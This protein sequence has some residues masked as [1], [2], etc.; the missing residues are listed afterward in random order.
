M[1]R[2]YAQGI[3]ILLLFLNIPEVRGDMRNKIAFYRPAVM[4][5]LTLLKDKAEPAM[6]S[7]MG[8]LMANTKTILQSNGKAIKVVNPSYSAQVNTE[9]SWTLDHPPSIT[10]SQFDAVLRDYNSPASGIGQHVYD[11]AKAK[12]IDN[13]YALFI[14]IH[15]STAGTNQNW[16]GMKGGGNS[17]HNPGN[18]ICAGY[19]SCYGGFR[20]YATWEDGFDALI[21]LLAYYRDNLGDKDINA[22]IYRWAPPSE[23]DTDGYIAQL[24]ENVGKWRGVNKG[25][26]VATSEESGIPTVSNPIGEALAKALAPAA[27]NPNGGFDKTTSNLTLSGCLKDT[28]P[29]ALDPSP[30]LKDVTIPP[31]TDWSFNENWVIVNP[32][33]H[34]CGNINYGGVCDMATRYNIAAKELGLQ[35]MYPRHPGGLN[36][37]DPD[38]AVVIMSDGSR[39]GQDLVIVNNTNKTVR[40]QAQMQE[41]NV[42]SVSAWY[43]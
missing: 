9:N 5:Q 1:G 7:I 24:K 15:E 16:A 37:V 41:G 4:Q 22:A 18:I 29:N 19:S 10:A 30:N 40:M 42:F 36:G 43:E 33:A 27:R 35:T 21:D 23:N 3:I 28:V 25:Q 11:Y 20:D 26:F 38:D 14:F 12:K 32:S 39:G 31:N 8:D 17:T 34:Y 2:Y 13:A 6:G